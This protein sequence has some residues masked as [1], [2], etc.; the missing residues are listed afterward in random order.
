MLCAMALALS[1]LL[2]GIYLLPV[3]KYLPPIRILL[4]SVIIVIILAPSRVEKYSSSSNRDPVLDRLHSELSPLHPKLRSVRV[5]EG[6]KSETINKK[7][8]FLCIRDANGQYYDE[9]HLRRVLLHEYA[10]CLDDTYSTGEFHTP[11]FFVIYKTLVED[12][13]RRGLFDPSIPAPKMY[14][15]IPDGE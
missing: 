5:Q 3:E 6:Q 11:K 14:C 13:T 7:N 9:N 4:L 15:G 10:H 8:V 1:I 2:V 12:A